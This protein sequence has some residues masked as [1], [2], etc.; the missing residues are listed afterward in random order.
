HGSHGSLDRRAVGPHGL[1]GLGEGLHE[2]LFTPAHERRDFEQIPLA[3]DLDTAH[4]GRA[5]VHDQR[6]LL[7]ESRPLE[8]FAAQTSA[9]DRAATER[10]DEARVAKGD[11]DVLLDLIERQLLSADAMLER[12]ER[13]RNLS[14]ALGRIFR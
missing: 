4:P 13:T 6:E 7:V 14:N 9:A 10:E 8:R 2:Y 11:E 3:I 12:L 1:A 5:L